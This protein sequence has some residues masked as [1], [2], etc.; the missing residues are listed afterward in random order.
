MAN[1][2]LY[3]LDH[4]GKITAAE[5]IEA[6]DDASAVAATFALAKSTD[7]ELWL[8]NRLVEHIPA[9]RVHDSSGAASGRGAATR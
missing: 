3:C 1:Y 7:C 2:R 5:W 4:H 9:A 6:A 8:H